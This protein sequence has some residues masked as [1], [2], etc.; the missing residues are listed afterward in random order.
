[1]RVLVGSGLPRTRVFGV[2]SRWTSTSTSPCGTFLSLVQTNYPVAGSASQCGEASPEVPEE[3]ALR[4][5]IVARM[6]EAGPSEERL[7][8]RTVAVAIT[9]ATLGVLPAFLT[10]GMAV[11][12]SEELGFGAAQLG[13][14]VALFFF[15]AALSAVFMGRVVERVGSHAGMRIA[16][17]SSALS[18]LGIAAFASSWGV[19]V[20]FL[21]L[22]GFANSM[23]HP[24]AN[25]SLAREVPAGR[26]GLSFGIKQASIPAATLLAGLAVPFVAVTLGWRWAFVFGAVIAAAFVFLVPREEHPVVPKPEGKS[27]PPNAKTGSLVLLALGIGL[28]STAATPLGSFVVSWAVE[29]GIR[30]ET[31]GFLLAAGSALS[32]LVRVVS[33]HL[34]DGMSGG[35]L[36]IV[37]AMLVCGVGGF[38]LLATG[39]PIAIVLGTLLAF[40]AGWGWPGLFN[41][42]V[43]KS[44]PSA[45]A[46]ATGVTQTGASAGAA[47]GPLVFGFVAEG[48]SFGVAWTLCGVFALA[49]TAAI[50]AARGRLL[51]GTGKPAGGRS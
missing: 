44:S 6:T 16:A 19:L 41:F 5:A 29:S 24:A 18:M 42:A 22:G 27:A 35:R 36:R 39:L 1:M 10:G 20:A 31:A 9:V 26:Q 11:Q 33:G 30:V 17:A 15:A 21:A 49:A 3:A 45:P 51:A 47:C 14:A 23:S 50:L 32:I 38:G 12:V 28:G 37:A 25:L 46:A 7:D 2:P 40:A 34:A 8:L 4:R 13:L 48:V 43:V